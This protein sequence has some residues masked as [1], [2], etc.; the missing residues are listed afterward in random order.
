VPT[1]KPVPAAPR[2]APK[3]TKAPSFEVRPSPIAGSGVFAT[4]RIRKGTRIIEYLGQRIS[5]DE[6][7]ARYDDDAMKNHH[8]VLF[9]VDDDTVI[10]AAV[11][12]ND[13]R[14][15]NHTCAPNC[16]AVSEKGRIF[17]EAIADIEPGTELG[18]DYALT[19]DEPWDPRWRKLYVCRCGAAECK[20]TILRSPSPPAPRKRAVKATSPARGASAKRAPPAKGAVTRKEKPRPAASRETASRRTRRPAAP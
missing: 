2:P 11:G 4:R 16:E 9:A 15:I 7:D 12:G 17:I 20:G 8:T 19:R 18:Y 6:A 10:D 1:P 3:R 13:A 14:F 5:A